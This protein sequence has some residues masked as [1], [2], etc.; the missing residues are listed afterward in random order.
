M[1]GPFR[2]N[3]R[4]CF[5]FTPC[6]METQ[7]D[8]RVSEFDPDNPSGKERGCLLNSV[9]EAKEGHCGSLCQRVVDLLDR[10][11]Q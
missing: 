9:G 4:R 10:S 1:G 11:A 8:P 7:L 5:Q 6:I 3:R 2:Y